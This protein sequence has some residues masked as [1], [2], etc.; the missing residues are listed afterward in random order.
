MRAKTRTEYKAAWYNEIK[1]LNI[2]GLDLPDEKLLE[3]LNKLD[4]LKLYVDMAANNLN[5][6]E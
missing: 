5:L 3:Y 4:E 1:T 6:P 2:V